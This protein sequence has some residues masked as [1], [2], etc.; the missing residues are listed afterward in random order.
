MYILLHSK[1][2][3]GSPSGIHSPSPYLT[4][5]WIPW[6]NTESCWFLVRRQDLRVLGSRSSG[7]RNSSTHPF[8]PSSGPPP[9]VT[10]R[11]EGAIR[12]GGTEDGCRQN[13]GDGLSTITNSRWTLGGRIQSVDY[14][15]GTFLDGAAEIAVLMSIGNCWPGGGFIVFIPQDPEW[16]F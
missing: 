6:S 4:R 15:W 2:T 9:E 16:N 5:K 14:R 10:G 13:G 12:L 7:S 8:L 1:A 11:P 3:K